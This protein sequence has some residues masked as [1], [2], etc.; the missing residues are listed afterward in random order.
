MKSWA[1]LPPC[2]TNSVFHLKNA[3]VIPTVKSVYKEAHFVNHTDARLKSDMTVNHALDSCVH[4]EGQFTRKQSVTVEAEGIFTQSLNMNTVQSEIPEFV[5][6]ALFRSEVKNSAKAQARSQLFVANTEHVSK[7]S[8]QGPLLSLAIKEGQDLTW[9]S[10]AFNLKKGALKFILNSTLDTLPTKANLL[11]WKK[12]TSDKC[13]LCNG[14]QTTVH[15]LS[16]CPVILNQGRLT[17]RHD[18]IVNYIA[19]CVDT[20]K[21]QVYADVPGHQTPAGGTIPADVLV[22]PDRPDIVIY[23]K[24]KKTMHVFELTVPYE[25]NLEK[26]HR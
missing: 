25:H 6:S 12:T 23:D 11:Q 3:H 8:K 22:T 15:V 18:G 4:R 10:F 9:K 26:R 13:C 5:A 19:S 2:A 17:W 7:L 20:D 16:A 1:G 21:F 14:R 24:K